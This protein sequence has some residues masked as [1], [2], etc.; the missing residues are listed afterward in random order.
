MFNITDLI[1]RFGRNEINEKSGKIIGLS[2][3]TDLNEL[4]KL[5]ELIMF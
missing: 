1:G 4:P 3:P 5:M 2:E